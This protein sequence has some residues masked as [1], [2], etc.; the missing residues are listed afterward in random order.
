MGTQPDGSP[1]W[2]TI[3]GVVGHIR[4]YGLEEEGREQTY[5]PAAQVPRNSMS[6]TIRT[7]ADPEAMAESVRKLVTSLDPALP[8]YE[9]NTMSQWLD[10]STASRRLNVTLLGIFAA[11]AVVMALIGIYGVI[12][13]SVVMRTHEIGIRLALG[14]QRSDVAK[15]ILLHGLRILGLGLLIGIAGAALA[16]RALSSLL[17]GIR[18]TDPLT[19]VAIPVLLAGVALIASYLPARRA[20][21]VDPGIALRYE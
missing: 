21:H 4:H 17:F 15:M 16:T 20:T 3:V 2:R 13:Y 5:Y 7:A 1:T 19:F 9:V 18:A 12:S 10:R 8:L 6:L 14:A 11:V